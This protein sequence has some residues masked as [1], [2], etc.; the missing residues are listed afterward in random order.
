[1]DTL[2]DIVLSRVFGLLD[3][4]TYCRFA[5]SSLR[6]SLVGPNSSYSQVVERDVS[7]QEDAVNV[8]RKWMSRYRIRLL[9]FARDLDCLVQLFST[10]GDQ[11]YALEMHSAW[12]DLRPGILPTG[13][14]VL[15]FCHVFNRPIVPGT[16]PYGL[17]SLTLGDQFNQPLSVGIIPE[18]LLSLSFGRE[19]NSKIDEGALPRGLRTVSFGFSFNQKLDAGVLPSTVRTL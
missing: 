10:F 16:L 11:V 15:E 19:F 13:L 6:L 1:M 3:L 17:E 5:L 7:S 14:K 2:P 18:A 8:Y 9:N 12:Y 4:G